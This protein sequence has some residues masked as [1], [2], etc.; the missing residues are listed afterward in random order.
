MSS[1]RILADFRLFQQCNINFKIRLLHL[2]NIIELHRGRAQHVVSRCVHLV[3]DLYEQE[4]STSKL[5]YL[6][7]EN[8][9]LCFILIACFEILFYTYHNVLLLS[10][11]SVEDQYS[12]TDHIY[13]H[14]HNLQIS[15]NI[16]FRSF[17]HLCHKKTLILSF[18]F[19]I[20]IIKKR[21]TIIIC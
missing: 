18:T 3:L 17:R 9:S 21:K 1:Q 10:Y 13:I 16:P 20:K 19:I 14:I 2:L 12:V 6:S 7:R 11:Y 15:V 4:E 8:P 5:L